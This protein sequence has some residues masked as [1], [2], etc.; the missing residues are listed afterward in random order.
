MAFLYHKE[1]QFSH[2]KI[3][4]CLDRGLVNDRYDETRKENMESKG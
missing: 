4:V 3:S 2:P 1:H